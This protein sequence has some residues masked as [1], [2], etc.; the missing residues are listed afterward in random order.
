MPLLVGNPNSIRGSTYGPWRLNEESFRTEPGI[1]LVEYQAWQPK[2]REANIWKLY[3][4]VWIIKQIF[5][6]AFYSHIKIVSSCRVVEKVHKLR[7]MSGLQNNNLD[8]IYT[9]FPECHS[10]WGPRHCQCGTVNFWCYRIWTAMHPLAVTLNHEL[11]YLRITNGGTCA[12]ETAWRST[13]LQIVSVLPHLFKLLWRNWVLQ[14]KLCFLTYNLIFK[15]RRVSTVL[16]KN[17]S[18]EWLKD[19]W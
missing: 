8:N 3:K 11:N 6:I 16:I 7:C 1:S 18:T 15:R 13:H 12:P 14:N 4:V 17:I 2:H 9:S 5:V 10:S 19:G